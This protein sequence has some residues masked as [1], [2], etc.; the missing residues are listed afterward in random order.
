[1]NIVISEIGYIAS[2][3]AEIARKRHGFTDDDIRVFKRG[4]VVTRPGIT[5]ESLFVVRKIGEI[6]ERDF[7]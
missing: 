7:A 6:I 2:D 1:M 3:V 5:D 4:I